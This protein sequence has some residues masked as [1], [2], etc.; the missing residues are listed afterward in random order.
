MFFWGHGTLLVNA[1]IAY[2]SY[3]ESKGMKALSHYDFRMTFVLAKICPTKYGS[4]KQKKSIAFQRGDYH[5]LSRTGGSIVSSATSTSSR[6]T[7]NKRASTTPPNPTPKKKRQPQI[8][9]LRL[10]DTYSQANTLRLNDELRHLAEPDKRKTG[11]RCCSLCRYATGKK[12]S[13]QLLNCSDCKVSLCMWCFKPYH[14][15]IDLTKEKTVLC[16]Q[17]LAQKKPKNTQN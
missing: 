3:V 14:T 12:Y 11:G 16:K 6:S 4:S 10:R 17:I 2:K 5:A 13:A 7:N 1:Y 8:T 9:A 15:L